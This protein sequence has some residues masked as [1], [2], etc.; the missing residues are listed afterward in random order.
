[1]ITADKEYI[2]IIAEQAKHVK[3]ILHYYNKSKDIDDIIHK[4]SKSSSFKTEGIIHDKILYRHGIEIDEDFEYIVAHFR[5]TGGEYIN[6]FYN[7]TEHELQMTMHHIENISLEKIIYDEDET[8][9]N[10]REILTGKEIRRTLEIKAMMGELEPYGQLKRIMYT[11]D[12]VL[13]GSL[14]PKPT[15]LFILNFNSLYITPRSEYK[16]SSLRY[17]MSI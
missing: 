4:A 15:E 16:N 9:P 2:R 12:Y 11:D 8:K 10:K 7:I 14:N 6:G 1:M 17:I 3:Y 5:A 13:Y